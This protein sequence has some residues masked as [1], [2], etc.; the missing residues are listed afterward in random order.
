MRNLKSMDI[1]TLMRILKKANV[2]QNLVQL[3]VPKNVTDEQYGVLLLLTVL[4]GVPE[5]KDDIIAFLSD[6]AGVKKKEL[7]EDEFEILPKIIEHLQKQEKFI[8][9]LSNAFKSMK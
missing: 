8:D 7:E 3:D 6:V 2:K 9:F 4:E 5:A 1:L